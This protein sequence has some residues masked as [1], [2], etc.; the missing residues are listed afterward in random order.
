MRHVIVMLIPL[1]VNFIFQVNV[2]IYIGN[3]NKWR[4]SDHTDAKGDLW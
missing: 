3:Y 4:Y 2:L 1:H